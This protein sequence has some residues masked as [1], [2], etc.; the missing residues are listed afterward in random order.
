MSSCGYGSDGTGFRCRSPERR[1]CSY[2]MLEGVGVRGGTL[3]GC[4]CPTRRNVFC[5]AQ[6]RLSQTSL[7]PLCPLTWLP[8]RHLPSSGQDGS[9]WAVVEMWMSLPKV[10][11]PKAPRALKMAACKHS[12]KCFCKDPAGCPCHVFEKWSWP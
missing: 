6:G 7:R 1:G 11:S 8:V 12:E 2:R 3:S 4:C 5:L 10:Y 9:F